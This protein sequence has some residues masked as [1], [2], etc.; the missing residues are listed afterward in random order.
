L[1]Y[2]S[3]VGLKV[4]VKFKYSKINYIFRSP[5][6]KYSEYLTGVAPI[7]AFTI[8]FIGL[9]TAEK[10]TKDPVEVVVHSVFSL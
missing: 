3:V 10:F 2:F 5:L 8:P 9:F 1:Y 7:V 4:Y 6:L